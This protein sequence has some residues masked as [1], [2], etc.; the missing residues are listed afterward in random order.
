M[1]P[2]LLKMISLQPSSTFVRLGRLTP[3]AEMSPGCWR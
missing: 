2:A 1:V 3:V